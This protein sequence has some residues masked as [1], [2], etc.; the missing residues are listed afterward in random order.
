[1]RILITLLLLSFSS[2]SFAQHNISKKELEEIYNKVEQVI[3]EDWFIHPQ[4][5]G[6]DIYFC[7]SCREEFDHWKH[8]DSVIYLSEGILTPFRYKDR[9]KFF[10]P[11][12]ADSMA[13]YTTVN[14]YGYDIGWPDDKRDSLMRNYYKPETNLCI[15][16]RFEKKWNTKDSLE[17]ATK[18]EVLAK[19]IM[20]NSIY[21]TMPHM[22]SDYRFWVPEKYVLRHATINTYGFER[23][24]Y[25]SDTYHYSIFFTIDNPSYFCA[26]M[27]VD[28]S[29]PYYFERDENHL[30]KERDRLL[31]ILGYTLGLNDFR[32]IQ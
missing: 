6:F 13:Y 26:P 20:E 16:Y 3:G 10:S 8:S 1:M 9:Y 31:L 22:F 19:E 27:Y 24:P 11:E 25:S 21:S 28:K 5:K 7:R 23:L 18:N 4:P 17:V 29:D 14:M 15:Q 12:K 30:E 32:F 2:E